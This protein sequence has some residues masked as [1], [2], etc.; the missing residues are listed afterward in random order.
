ML[1]STRS[2]S[3]L[4]L[5][6]PVISCRR[7][8]CSA[9][10]LGL[11]AGGP[12]AL[13]EPRPRRFGLPERGHVA[14]EA[15]AVDEPPL[16]PQPA[17]VDQHVLDRA[18][19]AP[20]PGRVLA[21]GLAPAEPGQEV[22]DHLPV[23]VELG[24]VAANELL[25]AVAEERRLGPVDPQHRAV[26][27]DPVQAQG[28][29]LDEVA[30]LPLL[31]LLRRQRRPQPLLRALPQRDLGLQRAGLALQLGDGAQ[32]VVRIG[33]GGVALRRGRRGCAPRTPRP[34]A[35]RPPRRRSRPTDSRTG[36]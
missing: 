26:R 7:W 9:S 19:L 20:Q 35:R 4:R 15:A 14:R 30:Q 5:S 21:Q 27:A 31:A 36:A 18:V 16:L 1:S 29:G 12:L 10:A 25:G 3:R 34:G 24:D 33:Q 23:G 11:P 8:V 2:A 6:C 22:V 17:G 13:Q 28:G 32:P